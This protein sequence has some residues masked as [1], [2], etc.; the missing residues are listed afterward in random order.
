[1][2]GQDE[3]RE[4]G[5]FFGKDGKDAGGKLIMM[6]SFS[7]IEEKLFHDNIY[8]SFHVREVLAWDIMNQELV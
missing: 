4:L 1:M 2:E 5:G 6:V 8:I 7:E 3:G